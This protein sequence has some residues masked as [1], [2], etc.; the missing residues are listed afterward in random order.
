MKKHISYL[1]GAGASCNALPI[2]RD[3]PRAMEKQIDFLD[4]KSEYFEPELKPISKE[5]KSSE[6]TEYITDLN[7]LL[8]K[9]REHASVDTFAKKL[10]INNQQNQLAI[11]KNCLSVFLLIEQLKNQVDI[12][13]DTFFANV[14]ESKHKMPDNL[15]VISWNYDMQFEMSFQAFIDEKSLGN[16]QDTLGVFLKHNDN[17]RANDKFGIYKLNGSSLAYNANNSRNQVV[18]TSINSKK[19]NR[20]ILQDIFK[21]YFLIKEDSSK[22]IFGLSFAWEKEHLTTF[23]E[24]IL[25]LTKKNTSETEVL[26]VIGYSIPFFNREIDREIIGAMAKLKKVYFQD[27]DPNS[28]IE[29]FTSIRTDIEM[30]NLIPINNCDQFFIPNEM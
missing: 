24:D 6:E 23:N 7:W 3:F 27:K 16:A 12:R 8:S 18:Y 9:S 19:F 11:L 25:T 10:Y 1:F 4:F 22:Y 28:I 26:V 30:H 20:E 2:L 14:L 21:N 29:R 17:W 15:K 13:Y 5:P